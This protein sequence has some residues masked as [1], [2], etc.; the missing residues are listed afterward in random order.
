MLK[1]GTYE[2]VVRCFRRI[3]TKCQTKSDVEIDTYEEEL[4]ERILCFIALKMRISFH[5]DKSLKHSF[6]LPVEQAQ[7]DLK[8]YQPIEKISHQ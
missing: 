1:Q 5:N 3:C 7:E 2:V 8:H 4:S 6:N